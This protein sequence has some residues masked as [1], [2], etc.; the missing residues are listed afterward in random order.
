[1]AA[2]AFAA[3]GLVIVA[4][5][6]CDSKSSSQSASGRAAAAGAQTP[7][8]LHDASSV[9]ASLVPAVTRPIVVPAAQPDT[10]SHASDY[11]GSAA[12]VATTETF[13]GAAARSRIRARLAADKSP[14]HL[15]T[16]SSAFELGQ[17]ICEQVVPHVASATPILLKPNLGGFD[18][19]RDPKS[20][21]GDNGVTGRTTDPEFVRG[22]IRCLKQRGHQKITVAD[23]FTGQASDWNRLVKI[24]GY[25]A[26]TTA[27]G[28]PL[29][30]M[31]DDGVFDVL[32]DKPGKPVA[33]T[34]ME[35]TSVPTLLMPRVLAWH[36][37]HGLY[38][39]LPKIKTHRYAVFSIG[40]KAQQ[41]TV[42][43]SD[44]APAFHQRGRSHREI[45]KALKLVKAKA[46]NAREVYVASLEKFA[47][48]MADV[49]EVQAP[50]IVLA[51]GAPAMS[52]DGFA[53]LFPSV[54]RVAIGGSNV[55]T[56]DR[57][58]AEF[59]GL[60]NNALLAK[61]LGG[62]S[63]S[64]LLEVAAKQLGID[65]TAPLVTGDGAGLLAKPRPYYLV[66]MANFV[67]RGNG[68][69]PIAGVADATTTTAAS[70]PAATAANAPAAVLSAGAMQLH[71]KAIALADAPGIDGADDRVW[72][73]ASAL[74]WSTN[75]QGLPEGITTTVRALWHPA[76]GATPATLFLRWELDDASLAVGSTDQSRPIDQ[77]RIDLYV[78]DCIEFFLAP[79]ALEPAR[80]FE[81][82]VG[83]YG[84]FF[85]LA[86]DRSAAT[87]AARSDVSW[88]AGLR[89]GTSRDVAAHH[90]VIEIA[91][92]APEI[93]KVL[94]TGATLPLGLYRT[95]GKKPRH[96]LAAFP[97]HTPKP[98]FHVPSAFGLLVLDE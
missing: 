85:D 84:H 98:N 45:G 70:A 51:E 82:E 10:I 60:W 7:A 22:V 54:E 36:L 31:D 17:R 5:S 61:E 49:L 78:E 59:L 23:G 37:Q 55:V 62:H 87:A 88:S 13:D 20:N 3:V 43:Y 2:S 50:D 73:R 25:A 11:A 29:V 30:A 26:M 47:Q 69:G 4:N 76:Q 90:A 68:G 72:D 33:I 24:S 67:V 21:H 28:V 14:V 58:G 12:P 96:Y 81:I 91:I 46:A 94:R 39:S 64:P 53:Q 16:G 71:A 66:G 48:R 92:T 27:E 86:I 44:A 41:G 79:N 15:L 77:E 52:G 95:E 80:Y 35:K 83:P 9:P 93:S 97:T 75:W 57:I 6:G 42:F 8:M 19:F 74:A 63:T 38:I 56:V 32:G 89:I 65:I 1:M 34:G 40:I 18:W